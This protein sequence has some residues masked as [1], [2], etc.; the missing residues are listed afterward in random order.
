MLRN[1]IKK[2]HRSSKTMVFYYLVMIISYGIISYFV[3]WPQQRQPA[4]EDHSHSLLFATC[5]VLFFL[6]LFLNLLCFLINPGTLKPDATIFR[7]ED[8]SEKD[9]DRHLMQL[10]E[11]FQPTSLCPTC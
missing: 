2:Q 5:N 3:I 10:L 8:C 1:P 9:G 7:Q 11:H 4:S 6:S